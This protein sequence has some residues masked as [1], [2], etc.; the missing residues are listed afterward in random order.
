MHSYTNKPEFLKTVASPVKPEDLIQSFKNDP[1]DF[2]PGARWEYCN[3]GYFLLGYLVEK[4]SGQSYG[5]FLQA[6][7]F[8]PLAMN[9][10]GVHTFDAILENEATGYSQEGS[11]LKKALDWDM[12]WAG[13]AGALYS[14]VRDLALWNDAVF[15]GKVLSEASLRAALTPVAVA[16]AEEP[17]AEGYGYGWLVGKFRGL[18]EVQH[19]GGLQGFLSQLSRYPDEGLTVAVLANAAPPVPGLDP[20]E[21][22][23]DVAQVFLADKMASRP[24]VRAV[25][26]PPEKLESVVGRYDY[27]GPIMTV[28][29][30]GNQLF[31]QLS[32][33]PR[34]EIFAKTE[35]E[36]FWKVV[37]AEVTFVKDE[38]GRVVKAQHRQGGVVLDAP[39]IEER[40]DVSMTQELLQACVG[41]YD[42]GQGQTIMTVTREG[43]QLFAQLTGQPRF[44]IFP[45][46]ET[47]F[48]WRVVKAKITFVKD[49]TGR[50]KGGIHEQGGSR[51]EVPRI[52]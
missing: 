39:R 33:Q 27:G 48:E 2:S 31:A 25:A 21:L 35:N 52:E 42:Y 41:K 8:G 5:D 44:E 6:Q 3:S 47:E 12:S 45:I 40:P 46:S 51:L 14:T 15:G 34:F 23:R 22:A 24:Q 49:A 13:G 16:G 30:E 4:V 50:V 18:S 17:P 28:T 11:V 7:F 38:S 26:V 20:G 10:T 36:F 37:E 32:G 9:D 1:F 43:N 19:G 29:R